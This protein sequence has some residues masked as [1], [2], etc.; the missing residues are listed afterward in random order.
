MS[1]LQFPGEEAAQGALVF[2]HIEELGNLLPEGVFDDSRGDG[3]GW[4]IMMLT[5]SCIRLLSIE[6]GVREAW[7]SDAA[8]ATEI[9][10]HGDEQD[11]LTSAP[12][13][14]AEEETEESSHGDV[15]EERERAEPAVTTIKE[16]YQLPDTS[17][18][19]DSGSAQTSPPDTQPTR[20][21]RLTADEY[22]QV[23]E[24][25]SYC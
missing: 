15:G 14:A 4:M 3:D 17:W 24:F 19:T 1:S 5:E 13:L 8:D 22:D 16:R 7:P 9:W 12:R 20:K 6:N 2:S 11:A 18:R 21:G 25:G 10:T 23:R